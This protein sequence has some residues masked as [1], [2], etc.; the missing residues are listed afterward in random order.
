M[1]W[2]H[3]TRWVAPLL[4][5]ALLATTAGCG[6]ELGPVPAESVPTLA[7]TLESVDTLIAEGRWARAR[8]Q[9]RSLIADA[10]TAREA[11]QLSPAEA[12]RIV[13]AATRLLGVL[14]TPTPS[15]TPSPAAV[16]PP[17]GGGGGGRED[18]D[19]DEKDGEDKGKGGDDRGDSK[20]GDK[21]ND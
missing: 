17:S 18:K 3:R 6:T 10:N 9:L 5:G 11:G 20:G 19:E 4:A 16:Q 12:D 21:G 13:A 2:R 1:T 8:A 7:V 14:P 15:V